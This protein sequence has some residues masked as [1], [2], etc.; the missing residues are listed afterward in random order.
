MDIG[1]DLSRL[2]RDILELGE[3]GRND[4]GGINR[5]SFSPADLAAREWLK[6][7]I[8]SAG[9]EYRV[10]GA[11][12]IFGRLAGDG[13]TVMAGSHLDS[14]VNGGIFDGPAGVLAALECLRCLKDEGIKLNKPL[15]VAAFTDEE[16][17]LS[18]D[19]MGSRAFTGTL[20]REML[21]R[22]LTQFGLPL[23]EILK[24]TEF[25][26]ESIL[27]AHKDR[28]EIAAFLE[29]H[30]EQ[31][32]VLETEDKVI[33]IV[34]RIAGKN[35][36]RCSFKGK[37]SH[38]GTTPLELRQDAFLGLADF[39]LK[40]TQFVATHHY[41]SMVT[42]GKASIYP[43]AF[44][45]VPELVDFSLDFRSTSPE[46]LDEIAANFQTLAQ[47]IAVTR[48]LGFDYRIMDK[49]TPV[50]ISTNL[51]T[52]MAEICSSFG[53]SHMTLPSGAGHDA[54][55]LAAVTD[56]ALIFIPCE[57]GISHS[58]R[59]NIRWEDLEKGT[60]LLLHTLIQLAS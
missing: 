50:E 31:G 18:G 57:D 16:G 39:M 22:G 10:D 56:A 12:N 43:G 59:E 48:G 44:S 25:T 1:I 58:P 38:A 42:V 37:A 15:E 21:E 5:P 8:L 40:S 6:D 11:G 45:I 19:F 17:N 41:G 55:I 29:L 14:V 54:Q 47:D 23:T 30:I 27:A 4:E 52:L 9:L 24:N 32:P 34:D 46:T 3:I 36:W 13:K 20:D 51:Q 2:R 53:Y 35:Y 7:K 26:L 49:T 33:G 60:H 28:P